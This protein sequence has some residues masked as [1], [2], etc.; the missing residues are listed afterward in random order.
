[1]F[2]APKRS[3]CWAKRLLLASE[4]W[5]DVMNALVIA[6]EPISADRSPAELGGA[7]D[8]A[9]IMV[10][11]PALHRSVLRFG[12]RTLMRRSD[13][14]SWCSARQSRASTTRD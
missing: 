8:D 14:R 11:A 4:P 10:V 9:E 3:I 1:M 12:P 5:G 2:R 6:S 13:G 7:S